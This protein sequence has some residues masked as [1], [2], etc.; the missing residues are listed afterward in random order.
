M[1][2]IAFLLFLML[3]VQIAIAFILK[4]IL[5]SL[6]TDLSTEDAAVQDMTKRVA[7]ARKRVPLGNE[8]T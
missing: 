5:K 4:E 3:I 6:G 7:E 2:W 1:N 8:K